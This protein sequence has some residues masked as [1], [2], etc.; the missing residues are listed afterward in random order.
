MQV[1]VGGVHNSTFFSKP[2]RYQLKTFSFIYKV[3]CKK[4]LWNIYLRSAA[5]RILLFQSIS[6]VLFHTDFAFP[7]LL[8]HFRRLNK[9]LK[10]H[11]DHTICVRKLI[12]SAFQCIPYGLYS[13]ISFCLSFDIVNSEKMDPVGKRTFGCLFQ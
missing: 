7:K 13:F 5:T 1:S 12:M 2:P 11:R 9:K 4:R 6:V 3:C 10:Y 8:L